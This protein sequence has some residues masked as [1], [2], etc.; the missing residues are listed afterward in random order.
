[1]S[2]EINGRKNSTNIVVENE[3]YQS[4]TDWSIQYIQKLLVILGVWSFVKQNPRK[5]E[6]AFSIIRI[7]TGV[8]LIAF[9]LIPL[10]IYLI[11]TKQNSTGKMK[12]FGPILLRVANLMKC[13]FM[14]YRRNVIKFCF[15]HV[16][17]DWKIAT[18]VSD[19]Q[20]MKKNALNGRQITLCCIVLMYITASFYQVILPFL[21]GKRIDAYNRTIRPFAYNVYDRFPSA[22]S[23]PQYEIIFYTTLVS[24]FITYT[25]T[26]SSCGIAA[27]FVTHACGQIEILM[28]RLNAIFDNFDDDL[29]LLNS[30]ISTVVELHVR[31]LRLTDTIEEALSEIFFTE[32]MSSS[33]LLCSIGWRLTG[34]WRTHDHVAFL[35]Y[36]MYGVTILYNLFIFCYIGEL[37]KGQFQKIGRAAYMIDWPRLSEKNGLA[38]VPIM[39]VS[40]SSRQLT[41]GHM[42]EFSMSSFG[43]IMKTSVM[44]LNMLRAIAV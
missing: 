23:S 36:S 25:T 30:R 20:I 6:L 40:N 21:R 2:L 43:I 22:Q 33:F 12:V 3:N 7:I 4:D 14:I 5:T 41:A 32:V 24:A 18:S 13:F 37:L 44:Y 15:A 27:T 10:L 42:M 11:T 29:Q 34:Q 31:I 39:A 35:T 19:H 28:S 1:M 26:I 38:I 9:V 16:K 8:L 17:N